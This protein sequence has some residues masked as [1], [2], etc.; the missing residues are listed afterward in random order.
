VSDLSGGVSGCVDKIEDL[1]NIYNRL[2][3]VHTGDDFGGVLGTISNSISVGLNIFNINSYIYNAASLDSL[4]YSGHVLGLIGSADISVL[5]SLLTDD[6][7]I[8]NLSSYV[9]G[10][11][12]GDDFAGLVNMESGG[13]IFSS[14]CFDIAYS[15][16]GAAGTDDANQCYNVISSKDDKKLFEFSHAYWFSP[17][18]DHYAPFGKNVDPNVNGLSAFGGDPIQIYDVANT[19]KVWEPAT[20]QIEL[21][22]ETYELPVAFTKE[23][24]FNKTGLT[25]NQSRYD[26][27]DAWCRDVETALL[28]QLTKD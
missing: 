26:D 24:F 10:L 17:D 3:V 12:C 2:G 22:G 6:V 9:N 7:E 1:N 14:S 27:F 16:F 21:G 18:G 11:S 13:S 28:Q 4:P 23:M 25:Y 8:N 20:E 15:V 5:S 19:I